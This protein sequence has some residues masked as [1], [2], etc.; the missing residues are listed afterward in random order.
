MLVTFAPNV[1]PHNDLDYTIGN[2]VQA[3]EAYFISCWY[4]FDQETA[5]MWHK[6]GK[7]GVAICSRYDLLKSALDAMPDRIMLGL[8]RY[9]LN[10]VGW[11]L[12]RFIT[13]K[14]PEFASEREVRAL[15]W[16]PEWA[17]QSRHI[18]SENRCHRIP[19]TPPPPHVLP[20]LRRSVDLSALIERIVI[21]PVAPK[22][23][24][25]E[26]IELL[27]NLG[28]TISVEPS[29]LTPYSHLMPD[30]ADIERFSTK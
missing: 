8:V 13:T 29:T 6:Y 16:K 21:S 3:K 22:N 15:I 1:G 30:L 27:N 2:L 5:K 7:E 23:R 11:N 20:G 12:L 9:S 28:Y 17:G 18:D 26:V 14:R 24:Y 10:N 25:S 4:L 19:L